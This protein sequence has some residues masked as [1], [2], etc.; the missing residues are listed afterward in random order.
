MSSVVKLPKEI[1]YDLYNLDRG[2]SNLYKSSDSHSNK[3]NILII[4]SDYVKQ[5]VK[6]FNRNKGTVANGDVIT[7]QGNWFKITNN[8]IIPELSNS[9][10]LYR[11]SEILKKEISGFHMYI[12][13]KK[14]PDYDVLVYPT[15][16]NC[17]IFLPYEDWKDLSVNKE[18]Y[19]E[20]FNFFKHNYLYYYKKNYNGTVV[21]ITTSIEDDDNI[22]P[23]TFNSNKCIIFN[24]GI[25]VDRKD[26]SSEYDGSNN[27]TI[28][29]NSSKT[30]SLEV[31]YDASI[32]YRKDF[33]NDSAIRTYN[34][35]MD[36]SKNTYKDIIRGG[37]PKVTS[38]IFMN[39]L[40]LYGYDIEQIG[41]QHYRYKSKE[42]ISVSKYSLIIHDYNKIDDESFKIYGSDYYLQK[43]IG[44]DKLNLSYDGLKTGTVFDD[45]SEFNVFEIMCN[46]G[47]LYDIKTNIDF[48]KYLNNSLTDVN[49]KVSQL[50]SKNPSLMRNLLKYFSKN[51][52]NKYIK[53]GETLPET[54]SLGTSTII[55]PNK[56]ISYELFCNGKCINSDK[57]TVEE[58][59]DKN[60]LEIKGEILNKNTINNIEV[61]ETEIDKNDSEFHIIKLNSNNIVSVEN[62]KYKYSIFIQKTDIENFFSGDVSDVVL[63]QKI[64]NKP[65]Y[66]YPFD[67]K[68]GYLKVNTEIIYNDD[69]LYLYFN[70]DITVD[71]DNKPTE[72]VV[73]FKNFYYRTSFIFYPSENSD[74]KL[75][76][77]Q[78]IFIGDGENPIPITPKAIP[79]LYVNN[80]Y[81]LYGIDYSLATPEN[82]D[83]MAG[84]AILFTRNTDP[85]SSITFIVE[86]IENKVIMSRYNSN[87]ESKY[88]LM[89]FSA[90][91]FP[92]SLDYLELFID[93]KRIQDNDIQIL[94][95]K[96]IRVK[97]TKVPFSDIYLSTTFK[98][99]YSKI[100]SLIKYYNTD[101]FEKI[102]AKLFKDV[103]LTISN[104]TDSSYNSDEIF[105]SFEDDIGLIIGEDSSNNKDPN[106]E[107]SENEIPARESQYVYEYVKWALSDDAK[108][109]FE[110]GYY[111]NKVVLDYFKLYNFGYDGISTTSNNIIIDTGKNNIPGG[112]LII[113]GNIEMNSLEDRL[114]DIINSLTNDNISQPITTLN[115]YDY[116]KNHKISNKYLNENFPIFKNDKEIRFEGESI[117]LNNKIDP[118]LETNYKKITFDL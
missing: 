97:N 113:N 82:N 37:V 23:N 48:N 30:G 24:N 103:D 83:R 80:E 94:S 27:I 79:K 12:D 59:G 78:F 73:Y 11:M 92:F 6:E 98:Y 117:I 31:I 10:K 65:N 50:I 46:L 101:S 95:D 41:R 7:I 1:V 93:G 102:I 25:L 52:F 38:T 13:K 100:E 68:I 51:K 64:K 15:E 89:Y 14:V 9:K 21:N 36:I 70:E 88:G 76:N 107:K 45:F 72:L 115:I 8:F 66:F 96:L 33:S 104:N 18:I 62:F 84:S 87:Y 32:S 20:S 35:V 112:N 57:Y 67:N 4:N 114:K 106:P 29:F 28:N 49:T 74:S 63:Y 81:Y 105:E 22:I 90:L 109:Q 54:F 61:I 75:S 3:N 19:F 55:D 47:T 43:M 58:T 85:G 2:G 91:K 39:G 116:Y 5:S 16:S 60:T 71:D 69:G 108:S 56:I 77:M 86:T 53:V 111:I 42:E 40:R 34:Y 44:N 99:D 110:A 26:Y 118:S 17:D